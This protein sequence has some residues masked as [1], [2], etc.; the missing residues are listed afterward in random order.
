MGVGVSGMHKD[1]E[2]SNLHI[3]VVK[4]PARRKRSL[5]SPWF[6]RIFVASA[7]MASTNGFDGS[8]LEE[9]HCPQS[10]QKLPIGMFKQ[11]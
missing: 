3:P 5:L 10:K 7:S 4:Q 2:K 1:T 6:S 8:A 9:T 11:L